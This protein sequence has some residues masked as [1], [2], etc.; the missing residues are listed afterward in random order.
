MNSVISC[1]LGSLG[2]DSSQRWWPPNAVDSLTAPSGS[3]KSYRQPFL[4]W[5]QPIH[6]NGEKSVVFA[7]NN[8]EVL[9]H[10][11]LPHLLQAGCHASSINCLLAKC[12]FAHYLVISFDCMCLILIIIGVAHCHWA[13]YVSYQ[14]RLKIVYWNIDAAHFSHEFHRKQC[15]KNKKLRMRKKH[16]L[17]DI[18]VGHL[19]FFFYSVRQWFASTKSSP[20]S[21]CVL[22]VLDC[23]W[24]I[25]WANKSVYSTIRV[26]VIQWN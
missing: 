9:K 15:W 6:R 2:K 26:P 19:L 20:S 1:L 4:W 18:S 22:L 14:I 5:L 3:S 12:I 11:L 13:S 23:T 21:L 24:T 25:L 16:R 7:I 8:T 17:T 10:H